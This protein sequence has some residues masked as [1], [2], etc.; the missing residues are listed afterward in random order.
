MSLT[1]KLANLDTVRLARINTA[2]QARDW[3]DGG[4]YDTEQGV[5]MDEW[6][7]MVRCEMK[8]RIKKKGKVA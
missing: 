4:M 3:V 1:E 8:N 5:T 6:A 2:L 7:E